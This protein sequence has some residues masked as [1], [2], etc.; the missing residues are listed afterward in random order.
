MN[1]P[2]Y[3]YQSVVVYIIGLDSNYSQMQIGGGIVKFT[4]NLLPHNTS[5]RQ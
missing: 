5:I 3:K 4:V 1:K 2:L